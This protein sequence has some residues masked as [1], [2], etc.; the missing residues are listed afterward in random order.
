MFGAKMYQVELKMLKMV[1]SIEFQL[2]MLK[3]SKTIDFHD[4]YFCNKRFQ[5]YLESLWTEKNC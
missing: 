3:K 2:A 1:K 5:K 4:Q